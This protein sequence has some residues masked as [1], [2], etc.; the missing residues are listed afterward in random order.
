MTK[1]RITSRRMVLSLSS[2]FVWLFFAA[3]FGFAHGDEK[4]HPARPRELLAAIDEANK[5]VVYDA[6]P[7]ISMGQGSPPAVPLYSS[8]DRS[9][10]SALHDSLVMEKP[11]AWF[12]CACIPEVDIELWQ[13]KHLI[14][15]ISYYNESTLGFSRWSGDIR[16]ADGERIV[17]WFD[18]RGISG[19]RRILE[20][21]QARDEADKVAAARWLD[22]MPSDLRPLWPEI[23]KNAQWWQDP[24]VAVVQS[25]AALK[26]ALAKEY[27]DQNQRIRALFSWF[28]SGS[29]AWSGYYAWE[30]VPSQMLL[31]YTAPELANALE[32]KPLTD[33]ENEGAARLF[34]GYTPNA[35]F[36]P[37]GDT[38]LIAQLP[39]QLKKSLVDYVARTG[40]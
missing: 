15:V 4:P 11:R 22:A 23:L 8:E 9:D 29:G 28:G 20:E 5:I 33:Q 30:D 14:G 6:M 26:R 24:R 32:A 35:L 34:V 10:I 37:P 7:V 27:P 19:P 31:E 17:K 3:G 38:T 2:A 13:K 21:D 16:L 40:D 25:A 1:L 36:R 39:E 12:R 18:A